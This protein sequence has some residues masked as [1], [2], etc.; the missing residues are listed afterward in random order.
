MRK[1]DYIVIGAGSAGAVL[2][3]RLS[4]DPRNQVLLLEEGAYPNWLSR[5]PKGFG[6]LLSDPNF[7]HFYP[8]TKHMPAN[9]PQEVWLRG[10]MLGGSSAINGMVWIRGAMEDYD[11]IGAAGNAGWNWTEMLRCFRAIER[12]HL[13]PDDHRGGDGPVAIQT[14]PDRSRLADA[15]I[16]AGV[17]TGLRVKNDQNG[18][19]LEGTGYAQW[20][21]DE[22]GTRVSAARAF[23]DPA[24]GRSNLHV[25]CGVR[26]ER[27]L[28]ENRRAVGVAATENG[29]PIQFR[30]SSTVILSAGAIVTPKLLQLSGI[31]DAGLLSSLGVAVVHHSPF[32]GRRMKE[33]ILLALNFRLK[34]WRDSD[35]RE[36][37]GV[38]LVR[39]IL[40]YLAA[41]RG[42]MA[43]GAAEAIAF[44]RALPGSNRADTQ[45]MFNPY[46]L[47]P[48]KNSLQFEGEPGMQSYSYA[49]RPES[50]GSVHI[51]S[52]D[53]SSPLKI[54]PNYLATEHDRALSIAGTRAIRRLMAQPA[55][56]GL[57]A[58]ETDRSAQAQ[59]DDEILDLYGRYGQSGYHAVGTASM[60]PSEHDVVDER[61]RVRGVTGLR[62]ADCSVF[63]QIPSGN[64]N[65]PAMALG[66]R[67]GEIILEDAAR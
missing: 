10:K 36:Y 42:P 23:L 44:V 66:W 4:V 26:V 53:P 56:A 51:S 63:R 5:M 38:R 43:R 13:G 30:A 59:S 33:H 15:F 3:E 7:S 46:S 14:N 49:L 20:N 32:V 40:R 35:N 54:D 61:L 57:V 50:E 2:A 64:T 47:D 34:H 27:I 52:A 6:K 11:G 24:R 9:G 12:H 17:A 37:S 22:R 48:A 62:V 55:L 67:A 65:A 39:N 29:Q 31:G 41:G 58:G 1:I 60:G 18:P 19:Q 25:R 16:A 8:T 21:I 28:F 45:I